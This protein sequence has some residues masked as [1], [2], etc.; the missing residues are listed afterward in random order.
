MRKLF[1]R[2]WFGANNW[3]LAKLLASGSQT[4]NCGFG[5]CVANRKAPSFGLGGKVAS[6]RNQKEQSLFVPGA[7]LGHALALD[8]DDQVGG[9]ISRFEGTT[10][11]VEVIKW[12][13]DNALE[14]AGH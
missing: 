6:R 12:H 13:I 11:K 3:Q 7:A 14:L 1:E 4:V 10:V 2:R 5:F 8:H 9:R